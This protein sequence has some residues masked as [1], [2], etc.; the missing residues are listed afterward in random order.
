MCGSERWRYVPRSFFFSAVKR[1][2]TFLS[3]S[4]CALPFVF[5]RNRGLMCSFSFQRV[6]KYDH[7]CM[8]DFRSSRAG[9]SSS[10]RHQKAHFLSIKSTRVG[11]WWHAYST[12]SA[13]VARSSFVGAGKSRRRL[14]PCVVALPFSISCHKIFPLALVK[15]I[16]HVFSLELVFLLLFDASSCS[17]S[18]EKS[19]IFFKSF[20]F[21]RWWSF[22]SFV[23]CFFVW[24][25]AKQFGRR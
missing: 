19:K 6:I 16:T 14:S 24:K 10:S 20:F 9:R 17:S 22:F 7:T 25:S 11:R 12:Q 15:D 18:S 13:K 5:A 4:A 2:D 8:R 23:R 21:E 3:R 1:W